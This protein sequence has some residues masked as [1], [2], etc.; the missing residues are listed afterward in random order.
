[1]N[2]KTAIAAA[3][4]LAAGAANAAIDT[5]N[6]ADLFLAVF[7]TT[8][9]AS[10]VLDLNVNE[11][12]FNFAAGNYSYSVDSAYSTFLATSGL[13]AS[14]LRYAVYAVDNAGTK[15]AAGDYKIYSTVTA[16]QSVVASTN[17][18]LYTALANA[19][20]NAG[21]FNA[22]TSTVA[23]YG[24]AAYTTQLNYD[25]LSGFLGATTTSNAVGTQA[26]FYNLASS[27]GTKNTAKAVATQLAGNWNFNGSVLT[28]TTATTPA[29]PEASTYAMLLAGLAAIGF[30]ARRRAA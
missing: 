13:D 9:T 7:D 22:G 1:M 29:V 3:A 27:G 26:A 16:G 20:N 17:G 2:F 18:A 28:Y 11:Q 30:V 19:S 23:A 15:S 10:Y 5:T 21:N 12:N 4:V 24:T 6:T 14:A 25:Q 8:N